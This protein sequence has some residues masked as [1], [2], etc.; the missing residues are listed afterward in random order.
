MFHTMRLRT[1]LLVGIQAILLLQFVVTGGFTLMTFLSRTRNSTERE[2]EQDWG[3]ARSYIEELK[4]TLYTEIYELRFILKDTQAMEAPENHMRNLIRNYMSMTDAD[5]ILLLDEKKNTLA[6]ERA[7]I[8]QAQSLP[9]QLIDPSHFRFPRNEFIATTDDDGSV[10]LY[11]ITGTTLILPDE[12]KYRLYLIANM[13][14]GLI[15]ELFEKTRTVN[16]FFVGNRFI[17]SSA[18]EFDLDNGD[19]RRFRTVHIGNDPYKVFSQPISHDIPEKVFLVS[20]KS[21]SE[22]GLSI[23]PV[24]LSYLLAF[25]LALSASLFLAAWIMAR[26]ISPF[27]RLNH[28]LHIYMDTGNVTP[29]D[30]RSRDEVGFLAGAFHTMITTLIDEKRIISEQLDQIGFLHAYSERIMNNIKAAIIVTDTTGVIEFSNTYFLELTGTD[31]TFLIGERAS[32]VIGRHFSLRTGD[33]APDDIPLDRDAVIEGLKL[34][35]EGSTAMFFTAKIRP[36]MLSGNRR[37]SLIVLEDTTASE[38]FWKGMM[39]ADKVTSLGLLSAGMAH[40]INNPLGSILS[41][42]DYL[43]AVETTQEKIASLTWIESETKRIAAIIQRI[44]AYSAPRNGLKRLADMNALVRQALDVLKFTLEKRGL[45]V[46]LELDEDIP[47]VSCAPDELNQ[48]IL[49]IVL[50]ACQACA[51]GGEISIS[52]RRSGGVVRL[53]ILDNGAGM[54]PAHLKNIFDPFFTTKPAN[55]GSGLGLSICYAIVTRAGGEI[56]VNSS[57]GRGT[58]VEVTLNVHERS[59]R[60]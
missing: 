45:R 4:H 3:R 46:S 44:L 40:E 25:L 10:A 53:S 14:K 29:L 49:N 60:R 36:I 31:F 47:P 43:K 1:K 41:H 12:R 8:A 11:L 20:F 28:W 35:K 15:D 2:L 13:D 23:R 18:S 33:S 16:A 27:S 6:D 17:A 59:Y 37:G 26:M 54:D 57:P 19:Q 5:R 55:E 39:I 38:S 58:E 51:K 9:P 32:R 56:R 52:T 50:N 24:L 34:E 48:V 22:E 30:I 7:G 21:L 42:V